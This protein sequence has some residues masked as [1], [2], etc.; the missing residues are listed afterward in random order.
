MLFSIRSKTSPCAAR[1]DTIPGRH[2]AHLDNLKFSAFIPKRANV[3]AAIN[4]PRAAHSEYNH[5]CSLF[6]FYNNRLLLQ[7]DDIIVWFSQIWCKGT[8]KAWDL[9]GNR[10]G[11]SKPNLQCAHPQPV[12]TRTAG[13]VPT[14]LN[15]VATPLPSRVGVGSLFGLTES[16]LHCLHWAWVSGSYEP[17]TLHWS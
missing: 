16:T 6:F 15:A 7:H 5:Y 4:S 12:S 9:Q 14:D 8:E 2:S 17:G 11:W 13:N 3:I 10:W 1:E